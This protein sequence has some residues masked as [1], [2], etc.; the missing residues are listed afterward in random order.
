M[1]NIDTKTGLTF[2]DVLLVPAES[3]VLPKDVDLT[4]CLARGIQLAIPV[5]SAAMDTVTESKMAI[6][7]A[8]MGGLGIIHR[9]MSAELQ[10]EEVSKVKK[11]ESGFVSEPITI[12]AK[13]TIL[14][15]RHLKEMHKV[16]GFPVVDGEKL[17]GILTNRDLRTSDSPD[18][19]VKEVMTPLSKVISALEGV[20]REEALQILHKNRIEKLP[21]VDASGFLKGLFTLKDLLS[22][23]VYPSATKDD[24]GRLRVGAAIGV[25][26]SAM[27]RADKLVSSGVDVVIIDTAHGHSKGVLDTVRNLREMFKDLPLIAGNIATESAAEALIKAG[28]DAVK[29]GVGPGSICTTRI[30]AGVGVPQITAIAG[31]AKIAR[32]K[33][34]SLISDGGIKFSGDIV[35]AIAAGADCVMMGSVLAG[36]D[37]TPGEVVI[38][39]G[40]SYKAYRGMGSVGAMNEGSKDRYAQQHIT[41]SDKLVPE[42]IEGRVPYCGSVHKLMYQYVGGLR[43]GMGYT[44]SRNIKELKENS[45]F[46]RITSAGLKESHAHDVVITKEAPNYKL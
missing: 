18:Q 31:C 45:S 41:E 12:T 6:A 11:F 26:E 25:G 24:L 37:E 33:G 15:A 32:K 16:S 43:S 8:E 22:F 35:K 1:F 42:G 27:E 38:Y 20:S 39:Q 4:T 21:V 34:V 19:P 30:I 28:V 7:M 40:R 44:G 23:E 46:I 13:D 17:I 5:V 29:I 36:T 3:N 2:D 9:N 10:A 14:R